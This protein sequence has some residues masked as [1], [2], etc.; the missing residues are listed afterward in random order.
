MARYWLDTEFY[1][2]DFSE[3]K[4]ALHKVDLDEDGDE[5]DEVVMWGF[6][7]DIEGED[8]NSQDVSLNAAIEKELGFVPEYE[9]N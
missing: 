7:R 6:W 5:T 8:E 1:Y 2:G 4:F 3:K 9:I